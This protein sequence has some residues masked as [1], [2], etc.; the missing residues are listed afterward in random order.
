MEQT[1]E[2]LRLKYFD[3]AKG[4]GILLMIIGHCSI[5]NQYI[6]NF[7]FSFHMPLFFFMSG[8][9][10][11]YRENKE[12]LKRNFKKLII[13]YIIT[14]MVMIIYKFFKLIIDSN[15]A[16]ILGT[17]KTWFLSSIY[18]SGALEPFGIK[19][20]GAIWFLWALFFA[21]YFIN[22]T[23]KSKYQY[24]WILLIGYIGYKTSKY[25]WLP[26]SI[27]AGMVATVFV[28]FGILAKRYDIFNK[29]MPVQLFILM[30]LIMMYCT[31]Y[32]GKLYMVSNIYT[33]GIIDFIGALCGSF[34]CIKL[35]QF[36]EKKTKFIK[37]GLIYIGENSLICLC[38]HLFALNCIAFSK[39]HNIMMHMGIESFSI[40]CVILHILMVILV[41]PLIKLIIKKLHKKE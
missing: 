17:I 12:E 3:I 38:I 19:V 30:V 22:I 28:Y 7:I 33:N 4:I 20:I 6:L 37:K 10:Y 25:I 18:G 14:C 39:V 1:N 31:I 5:K 34:L 35:S 24:L 13:P 23:N 16:E 36:I 9:F 27:Q 2:K 11:K 26:L 21:L 40:R 32:C 41:L 29:K 8:F 15:F